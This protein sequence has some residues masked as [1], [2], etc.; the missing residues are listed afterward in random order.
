MPYWRSLED[1]PSETIWKIAEG[2]L[3]HPYWV[4]KTTN[5][6]L[7]SP[8]CPLVEALTNRGRIRGSPVCRRDSAGPRRWHLR[9]L[10]ETLKE[11]IMRPSS[12]PRAGPRWRL[13]R[14]RRESRFEHRQRHAVGPSAQP[15]LDLDRACP[16]GACRARP[17]LSARRVDL[18]V[19]RHPARLPKVSCPRGDGR[20][21]RS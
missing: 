5:W 20:R 3:D 15:H 10:C 8:F 4:L 21:S 9:V 16:R 14:K 17:P 1:P 11:G 19:R 2:V 7:C 12:Q 18:P 6:G 13:A